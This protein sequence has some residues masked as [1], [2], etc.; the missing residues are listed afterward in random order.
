MS[1]QYLVGT[2]RPTH[3]ELPLDTQ[4]FRLDVDGSR[5]EAEPLDCTAKAVYYGVREPG[6]GAL[7]LL[8]N[9]RDRSALTRHRVT[10]EGA[11]DE[12]GRWSSGGDGGSFISFDRTGRYFAVANARTGWA[13]FRNAAVPELI[14]LRR[15]EGSGPHPRQLASHPHCAQFS[16]DNRWIYATDMGADEVLAFPFREEAGLVGSSVRAFKAEPGHGPRHLAFHGDDA[17]LLNE[18]GNSLVVLSRRE[19]G[20]L[21]ERQ[22]VATLPPDFPGDS[23]TAHISI[24]AERRTVYVSN[25]GHDSI[26][27][28]RIEEDGLLS[29][30]EWVPSGGTWPWFFLLTGDSQMLVANNM[31]DNV[32]VF[33][34]G[35]SGLPSFAGSVRIPSPAFIMELPDSPFDQAGASRRTRADRGVVAP[36]TGD[37]RFPD[38]DRNAP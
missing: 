38:V 26:A 11:V 36:V 32:A 28:F 21:R 8:R 33:D 16:P 9:D 17:Y 31:S 25:R 7:L 19:D 2:W 35:P 29:P 23:H 27:V 10:A 20:T 24:S 22:T 34:L 30:A 1:A 3:P 37:Q 13:F 12:E 5:I 14:A 4:S 15:N 6:T 18:L